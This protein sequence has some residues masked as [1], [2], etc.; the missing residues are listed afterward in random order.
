M[1]SFRVSLAAKYRMLFGCAV[2]L[3]I[4][5]AL[6]VPWLRMEA[7][8]DEQPFREAQRLADDFFRMRLAEPNPAA[9][10]L[11]GLGA[12]LAISDDR[13][14]P[15]FIALN[16]DVDDP[17]S[18]S[19]LDY[20]DEFV[21]RAFRRFLRPPASDFTYEIRDGQGGRTFLYAHAVRVSRSCLRC[22]DEAGTARPYRERQL[23]GLIR[24]ELP[25][26]FGDMQ[27]MYNR[28]WLVG[29]GALAGVLAILV[30]YVITHRF[31]L[32]P[33]NH[34]REVAI[35]VSEDHLDVRSDLRTGDEFEHL[36]SAINEMLARLEA[37]REDLRKANKLL[38]Q[39]LG[40]MAETNVSLFEANRIKNEFLANVTHELRTPLTNIIGFAELLRDGP[41][42]DANG[43]AARYAENILISGRILL[44][45]INDLLDL[46]K[47]EAG[48]VELNVES[49]R[50]EELCA[51]MVDFTRPAAEKKGLQIAFAADDDLPTL[52]TDRSKLRQVLFNLLS[53]AV[54]FTPP[55]GAITIRAVREGPGHVRI[56]VTDTGPGIAAEHGHLIFE[57]FRQIDGSAT[58]EQAGTGLGLAIAKELA[59]LLGGEI[60]VDSVLG[61]GSTFWIKLPHVA[62]EPRPRRP[63][64]LV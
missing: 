39:K 8:I 12:S 23:A 34:L 45:I 15:R 28:L 25:A 24:V 14:D 64:S 4:G 9:E 3:I 62:S 33:V 32:G 16:L 48:R 27:L 7:L 2:L 42:S 36:S 5:A 30:F 29:A 17:A 10:D 41:H 51:T 53:N 35:R 57:K 31:I 58:R 56:S 49:V 59:E 22:H 46:A 20:R 55:E 44:E 21:G 40:E 63:I 60:G 13:G 50:A 37:S 1:P 6:S 19:N 43:R 11:H 26:D 61:H 18:I 54:K 47:I 38:D 52:I